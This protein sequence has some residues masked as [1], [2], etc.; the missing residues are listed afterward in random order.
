MHDDK[1]DNIFADDDALDFIIYEELEKQGQERKGGK[2]GCLGVVLLLPA[3]SVML[4]S[5]K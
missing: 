3:V 5:W 1:H 4:L 2:G